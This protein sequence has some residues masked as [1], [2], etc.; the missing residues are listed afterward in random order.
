MRLRVKKCLFLKE[1]LVLGYLEKSTD[2]S[3]YQSA[4]AYSGCNFISEESFVCMIFFFSFAIKDF[5]HILD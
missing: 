5:V 2:S 4:L 1:L 3:T